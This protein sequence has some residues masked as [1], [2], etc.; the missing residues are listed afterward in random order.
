[1]N[2]IGELLIERG[3]QQK[4]LALAVGVSEP[5]VSDWVNQKKDPRGANIKKLADFFEVPLQTI[6]IEGAHA[7][8]LEKAAGIVPAVPRPSASGLTDEDLAKIAEMVHKKHPSVG[9]A[10]PQTVEARILAA[11]VDKMPESDRERALQA[12]RFIF[13]EYADYFDTKGTKENDT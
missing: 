8:A 1:M 5:T 13:L 7:T 11:G 2:K 6:K 12:M 4:E 3:I 10:V 9:E